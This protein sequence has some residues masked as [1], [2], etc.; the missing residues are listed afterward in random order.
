MVFSFDV[1]PF[2]DVL[3]FG[4]TDA[5]RDERDVPC[6]PSRYVDTCELHV[7]RKERGKDSSFRIYFGP[8][9]NQARVKRIIRIRS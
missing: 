8:L 6:Q 7:E 2:A 1:F 4:V 3:T 9:S 5:N